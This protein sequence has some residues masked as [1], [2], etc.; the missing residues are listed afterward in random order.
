MESRCE[1]GLKMAIRLQSFNFR[2]VYVRH[3][4][5]EGEMN[6][7]GEPKDDF[8]WTIEDRG[9]VDGYSL[10]GIRSVNFQGRFLR[11]KNYRIAL[12]Q[13]DNSELFRKDSTFRLVAGLTGATNEGWVSFESTNAP[14]KFIR[15]RDWHVYLEARDTPNLRPDA[16]F[17]RV[18]IT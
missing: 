14:G 1:E 13:D 5:F 12:D 17:K 8:A 2:E 7:L 6:A 10:V 18:K 15:H 4:N 3:H 16:T 9:K 11:H